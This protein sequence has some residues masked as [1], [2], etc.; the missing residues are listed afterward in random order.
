[1]HLREVVLEKELRLGLIGLLKYTDSLSVLT[2]SLMNKRTQSA[3]EN[4]GAR[5]DKDIVIGP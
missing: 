1:M 2:D 3:K 4:H 5:N